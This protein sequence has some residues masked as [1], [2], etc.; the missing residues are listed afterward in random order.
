MVGANQ[1]H[2]WAGHTTPTNV[3]QELERDRLASRC[4]SYNLKLF[5]LDC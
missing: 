2:L 3:Q 5:L 4:R 1:V